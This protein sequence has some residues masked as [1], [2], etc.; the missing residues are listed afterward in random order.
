MRALTIVALMYI[1]GAVVFVAVRRVQL[2]LALNVPSG[3]VKP[4]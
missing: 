3:A 1:Y 4:R 2:W